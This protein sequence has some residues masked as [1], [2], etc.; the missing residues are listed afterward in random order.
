MMSAIDGFS[1]PFAACVACLKYNNCPIH[2]AGVKG[3]V[4]VKQP[5]K[6][7][8]DQLT[9]PDLARLADTITTHLGLLECEKEALGRKLDVVLGFMEKFNKTVVVG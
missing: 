4:K 9:A 6:C 3:N 1:L 2:Q 8:L 5:D 7:V